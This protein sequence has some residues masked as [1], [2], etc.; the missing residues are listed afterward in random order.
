MASKKGKPV[1]CGEASKKGNKK[2]PPPPSPRTL[3]ALQEKEAQ[4]RAERDS[5]VQ[6]FIMVKYLADQEDC[7]S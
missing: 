3:A 1:P 2:E 4:E 7:M 6:E 5:A